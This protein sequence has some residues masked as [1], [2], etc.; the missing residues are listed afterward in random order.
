VG[1]GDC[2]QA[3]IIGNLTSITVAI[4]THNRRDTLLLAVQSALAQ[5]REPAQVIVVADGCTDGTAEGVRALD[6]PRI[7]LLANPDK[8]RIDPHGGTIPFDWTVRD[9]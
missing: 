7:E 1:R 8:Y 9:G 4:P 2:A 5:T 3:G 6:D